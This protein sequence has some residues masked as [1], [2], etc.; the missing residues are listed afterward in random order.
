VAEIAKKMRILIPLRNPNPPLSKAARARNALIKAAAAPFVF[1]VVAV[2]KLCF[3]WWSEPL[4]A[5]QTQK[6]LADDLRLAL[7]FLFE[8]HGA[9]IDFGNG[10]DSRRDHNRSWVTIS[11]ETV[12]LRIL[13][14]RGDFTVEVT[15]KFAPS[16][17]QTLGSVIA[18]VDRQNAST[19]DK[20]AYYT[21][22][23]IE[24]VLRPRYEYLRDAMSEAR[25]EA[26]LNEVVRL[27]NQVIDQQVAQLRERGIEPIFLPL[28][29]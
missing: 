23:N 26:T 21:I 3:A 19:L 4:Y 12:L 10:I 6:R 8:D 2:Y 11:A 13:R 24:G 28:D 14:D 17:W 15:S 27:H 25:Y 22:R 18:V 9:K 1:A 5:R 16:E 29:S 7:A 20:P